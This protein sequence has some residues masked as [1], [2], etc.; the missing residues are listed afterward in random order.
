M[1][2]NPNQDQGHGSPKVV[3]MSDFKVYLLRQYAHNQQ[4]NSEL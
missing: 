1:S 4:T 3:K 2:Y